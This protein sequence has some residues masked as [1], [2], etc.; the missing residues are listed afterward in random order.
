MGQRTLASSFAAWL[1]HMQQV[2]QAKQAMQQVAARMANRHQA[3]A[4]YAWQDIAEQQHHARETAHS[5]ML[6]FQQ[7]SKV[8]AG[9]SCLF[10]LSRK[11]LCL[12]W[13][14]AYVSLVV[15][16]TLASLA[17]A[18]RWDLLWQNMSGPMCVHAL[19]Q[20]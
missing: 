5:F 9:T 11:Q 3:A 7:A 19:C 2:R 6:R 12:S 8:T 1:G 10:R 15:E 18:P 13:L 16:E 20:L 14:A 4:F 17:A